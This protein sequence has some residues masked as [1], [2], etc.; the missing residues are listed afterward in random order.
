[1]IPLE[2]A[3]GKLAAGELAEARRLL[4]SA[5]R[6]PASLE[7][8]AALATLADAELLSNMLLELAGTL[9]V[10]RRT[11]R[12]LERPDLELQVRLRGVESA[13]LSGGD[14][15]REFELLR[16]DVVEAPERAWLD[17]LEALAVA[18][19]GDKANAE[20]LLVRAQKVARQGG[21]KALR[22]L[23]WIARAELALERPERAVRAAHAGAWIAEGMG[24]LGHRDAL[25][26]LARSAEGA[27]SPVAQQAVLGL[28]DLASATAGVL[29]LKPLLEQVGRAT[30]EL[31][32]VDRAFVVLRSREGHMRIA[33]AMGRK[34]K[35]SGQ[36]SRSL[37]ERAIR[38]GLP[39]VSNDLDRDGSARSASIVSMGLRS[40]ICAPMLQGAQALGV[41]YGDSERVTEH[42]LQRVAWLARG[43]AGVAAVAVANAQRLEAAER[44]TREGR[45]IA[46][47]VRN[48][49]STVLLSAE[50]LGE[51][52]DVPEW[53][54]ELALHS[55][56]A[57]VRM[58]QQLDRLLSP[59]PPKREVIR[60]DELVVEMVG[61]LDRL[62]Q[63]RDVRFLL[64]VEP[65][66]ASVDADELGRALTNL[67]SN[68]LKYAP[69]GSTVSVGVRSS[70]TTAR[71]VVRDQGP[72]IPEGELES[73]FTSG[74][75]ARGAVDG[76]GL[77]LGI[78]A[79]VAKDHG[80]KI[81]AENHPDGG[82][83]F[84]LQ[85]PA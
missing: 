22:V 81:W 59:R 70:P 83:R 67:L 26:R 28:V 50:D 82:A 30:M 52:D 61:L 56:S 75:Q 65:A 40:V 69:V 17:A 68:A 36:P 77:G 18:Q 64:D 31:L 37:V 27:A 49:L 47:D 4:S 43:I 1:V 78:A 80:G 54:R 41:I 46:H 73:I 85:L 2:R 72:G 12:E 66:D 45:E 14:A 62:A 11:A 74:V 9:A 53:A 51:A 48:L 35:T 24:M 57:S 42:E 29:D 19:R 79:R 5:R 39:V 15:A 21:S 33:A 63:Q 55:R 16:Q 25:A 3:R 6:A 8:F 20:R 34:G 13:M 38:T 58:K 10:A 44:R 71:I 60:V 23:P 7:K 84:V 32:E 76:H